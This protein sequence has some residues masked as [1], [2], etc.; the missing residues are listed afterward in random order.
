[1]ETPE[2]YR[3]FGLHYQQASGTTTVDDFGETVATFVGGGWL[4]G[5]KAAKEWV[6]RYLDEQKGEPP[7]AV[8]YPEHEKLKLVQ[9]E[10]QCQGE[11]LDWLSEQGINLATWGP[12][13]HLYPINTSIRDLLAQYHEI[14]QKVLEAEKR[15]MLDVLREATGG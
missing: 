13:E 10:S 12:H 4:G 1:M 9:A 8:L 6:D 15:Q 2:I 11:F 14:D 3:G 7:V 5:E